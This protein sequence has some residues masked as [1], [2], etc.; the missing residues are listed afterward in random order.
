MARPSVGEK[1]MYGV[2]L[3]NVS[4]KTTCTVAGFPDSDSSGEVCEVNL[5]DVLINF[6]CMSQ[7]DC[8]AYNPLRSE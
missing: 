2:G 8:R 5:S 4:A 1:T 7:H 3:V 6:P